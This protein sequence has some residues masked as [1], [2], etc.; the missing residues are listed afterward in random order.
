MNYKEPTPEQLKLMQEFSDICSSAMDIIMKCEQ[1]IMLQHAAARIQ[2]GMGWFH[3]YVINGG[4][5]SAEN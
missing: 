4:K 5:L 1:Q 3:G 2:E